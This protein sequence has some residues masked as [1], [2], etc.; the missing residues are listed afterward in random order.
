MKFEAECKE[1]CVMEFEVDREEKKR[2]G[3]VDGEWLIING[4]TRRENL[5]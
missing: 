4:N 5:G 2:R 1:C 3:M